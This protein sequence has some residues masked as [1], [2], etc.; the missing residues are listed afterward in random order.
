MH[1]ATQNLIGGTGVLDRPPAG[2][3]PIG[4]TGIEEDESLE[5]RLGRAKSSLTVVENPSLDGNLGILMAAVTMIHGGKTAF[6]NAYII[7]ADRA[8]VLQ[9]VRNTR[10]AKI[11]RQTKEPF[12]YVIYD[13]RGVAHAVGSL[14][15]YEL[16]KLTDEEFKRYEHTLISAKN[17]SSFAGVVNDMA[18]L[19]AERNKFYSLNDGKLVL[20]P[21]YA[22]TRI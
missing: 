20:P 4:A 16:C 19:L 22:S 9:E 21:N 8:Y 18:R 3:L 10:M 15:P 17:P 11:E 2:I 6:A 7:I 13:V 5:T 1:M 12:L 14:L